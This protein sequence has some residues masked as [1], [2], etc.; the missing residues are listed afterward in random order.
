MSLINKLDNIASVTYNG[1][2]VNS[3]AATTLLLLPPTILKAVDKPVASIG[4]TITYTVT[5]T[6]VAINAL[7]NLPFT[8]V[9]P[10][11]ATYVTDSF[12]VNGSAVTPTLANN[13]LTYT[14]PS[15]P[16][17]GIATIVFQATIVGGQV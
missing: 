11:G 14:I 17:L 10:A 12:K 2:P 5:I 3:N 16:S 8:D 1:S 15:I 9:V 13:T 6:N 4:E 7:T